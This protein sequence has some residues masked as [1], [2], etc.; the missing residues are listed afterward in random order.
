MKKLFPFSRPER[1]NGIDR[2]EAHSL[3]NERWKPSGSE[4]LM[5]DMH[6]PSLKPVSSAKAISL[7]PIGGQLRTIELQA[8]LYMDWGFSPLFTIKA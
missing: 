1:V 7:R 3:W 2:R 6:S 4:S 5:T 8:S